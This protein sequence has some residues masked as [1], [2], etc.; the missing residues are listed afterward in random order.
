MINSGVVTLILIPA[1]QHDYVLLREQRF[2]L[3]V[4]PDI[5]D[6]A[7]EFHCCQEAIR[8]LLRILVC[9]YHLLNLGR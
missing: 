9:I 1:H 6:G 4:S 5:H 8:I 2:V 7:L 3:S